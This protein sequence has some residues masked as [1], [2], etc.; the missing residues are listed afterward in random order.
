VKRGDKLAVKLFIQ[1]DS[2]DLNQADKDG[3]R[4][5]E[6]ARRKEVVEM[7]TAAGAS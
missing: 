5:L 4:P 1:A 7:L 2:V 6:L 3:K